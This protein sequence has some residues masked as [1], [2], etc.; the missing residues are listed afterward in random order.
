M[1][2]TAILL[3]LAVTVCTA[4]CTLYSR[5]LAPEAGD[6]IRVVV[7]GVGSGQE[8]EQQI[9]NLMRLQRLGFLRCQVI[10]FDGG[11]DADGRRLAEN[12]TRRWPELERFNEDIL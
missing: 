12:L 1:L 8:L 9:H 5:L 6:N 7:R 10:L 11:L 3:L 4:I 2:E